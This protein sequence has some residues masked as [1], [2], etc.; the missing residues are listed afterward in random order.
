MNIL[1]RSLSFLLPHDDKKEEK[2]TNSSKI[3]RRAFR[4]ETM[5]KTLLTTYII[6]LIELDSFCLCFTNR[7]AESFVDYFPSLS[8]FYS[9]LRISEILMDVEITD[10]RRERS[11]PTQ[12]LAW[13]NWFFS[14]VDTRLMN[15]ILVEIISGRPTQNKKQKRRKK[16]NIN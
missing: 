2:M 3:N 6:Y 12:T 13:E 16:R 5:L 14:D 1:L 10:R 15:R 11:F 8:A 7:T 9:S 4:F